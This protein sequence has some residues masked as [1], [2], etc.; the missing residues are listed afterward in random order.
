[1]PSEVAV[2]LAACPVCA[3]L[4]VACEPCEGMGESDDGSI[5]CSACHGYGMR[6]RHTFSC[7][8]LDREQLLGASI[9]P[10]EVEDA[11]AV[12]LVVKRTPDGSLSLAGWPRQMLP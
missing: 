8:S 2:R 5:Q 9:E 6:W 3:G 4:L 11:L 7:P 10:E 12:G 1:M